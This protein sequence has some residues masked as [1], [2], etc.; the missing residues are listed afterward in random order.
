M[1]RTRNI[2][3]YCVILFLA[4]ANIV[5]FSHYTLGSVKMVLMVLVV[6]FNIKVFLN[7]K[8]YIGFPGL[9]FLIPLLI[10]TAIASHGTAGEKVY[11]LYGFLENYIFLMLG[12]AYFSKGRN[13]NEML[14]LILPFTITFCLLIIGNFTIGVPNWVSPV[15]KD[16]YDSAISAGYYGGELAPMYSTG[17]GIARTGWATTLC[18]YLPLTLIL[19]KNKKFFIPAYIIIAATAILSASRGGL[20]LTLI[21]TAILFLKSNMRVVLKTILLLLL[22]IIA[23]VISPY[24][25]EIEQFLRL[26]G[27]VLLIMT[28][29]LDGQNSLLLSLK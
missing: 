13:I 19:I 26:A 27:G 22:A 25:A 24:I 3:S 15:V 17:F 10:I 29:Q 16:S 5:W 28:L 12:Y 7:S 20:F 11:W 21:I 14:R 4:L 23:L 6:L 1:I 18:S 9:L 8:N 2:G